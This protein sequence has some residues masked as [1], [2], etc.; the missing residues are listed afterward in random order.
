[1]E[2]HYQPDHPRL[3]IGQ[4]YFSPA[5]LDSTSKDLP[6][7]YRWVVDGLK[8]ATAHQEDPVK[9]QALAELEALAA[10]SHLNSHTEV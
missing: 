4:C 6:A 1:M 9:K 7:Y 2:V 5:L 8:I 3:S 10:N